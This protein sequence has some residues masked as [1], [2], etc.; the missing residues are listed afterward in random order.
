VI[1]EKLMDQVE[2]PVG[3]GVFRDSDTLGMVLPTLVDLSL[4]TILRDHV[5]NKDQR[6]KT[7]TLLLDCSESRQLC[8]SGIAAF[9]SLQK[10]VNMMHLRL[11]M[12]NSPP[13]MH[14]R[15]GSV[16]PDAYWID[17]SSVDSETGTKI[18]V[19]PEQGSY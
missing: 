18:P 15:L 14:D 5:L 11:F 17:L 1:L 16:L 10:L 3:K 2:K 12:I 8:D 7:S 19:N 4:Y 9:M 13:D 6:D